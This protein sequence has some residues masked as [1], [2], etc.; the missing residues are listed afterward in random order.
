[1]EMNYD[2]WYRKIMDMM[3]RVSHL[4]GIDESFFV[5]DENSFTFQYEKSDIIYEVNLNT[6][7]GSEQLI[8][9]LNAISKGLNLR[10]VTS[11]DKILYGNV[12]LGDVNQCSFSLSL[13]K[14]IKI[15]ASQNRDLSNKPFTH[16]YLIAN[17]ENSAN[18]A[19]RAI[20]I[21]RLGGLIS[22]FDYSSSMED[23]VLKAEKLNSLFIASVSDDTALILNTQTGNEEEININEIYPYIISYVKGKSK[24]SSCKDKEE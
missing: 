16:L 7:Y 12:I 5:K 11:N 8:M 3:I 21:C 9:L 13:N 24:C 1:M 19:L 10:L 6:S 23:S 22:L 2:S 15:I 4:Y 17:D 20:N 18:K 14:I